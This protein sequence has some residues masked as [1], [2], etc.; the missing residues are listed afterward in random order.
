MD[1]SN[2][3]THFMRQTHYHRTWEALLIRGLQAMDVTYLQSLLASSDWL[4]GIHN[5]FNA[6]SVPKNSIRYILLGESP[7][8][9]AQSANGYAFW[10]ESVTNLWS[11]TGLSKPVNRA[12][13]L[14]N[15]IKMLLVASGD[16]DIKNT[17]PTAIAKL[18]KDN[19]IQTNPELFKK[20]LEHGF[21]LLNASLT[22]E[23]MSVALSSQ[24][25]LPFLKTVFSILQENHPC[26]T[27]ILFGNIAKQIVDRA[28]L[29]NFPIIS[30]EHPYN[31]SFISN[32]DVIKL[33]KPFELLTKTTGAT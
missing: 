13:S 26:P 3:I 31:L 17:S 11:S 5:I 28:N 33:F 25:W 32:P 16:L 12:T 15:F 21:L 4:P 18:N 8:P 23:N 19:K 6:F 30:A 22:L 10:D 27:L 29:Q 2:F 9:R 14:R 1:K 7:Y 20:L 24:Q